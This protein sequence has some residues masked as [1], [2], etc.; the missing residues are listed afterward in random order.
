MSQRFTLQPRALKVRVESFNCS[1]LSVATELMVK[2]LVA[3]VNLV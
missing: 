1:D 3:I 2:V